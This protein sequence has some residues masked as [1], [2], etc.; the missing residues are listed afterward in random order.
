MISGGGGL[1]LVEATPD[2]NEQYVRRGTTLRGREPTQLTRLTENERVHAVPH[3]LPTGRAVLFAVQTSSLGW[4]IHIYSFDTEERWML[5]TGHSPSFA[6]SGHLL[7][8]R[9]TTLWA[10][11]FD[12]NRLEM[13]GE[14]VSVVENVATRTSGYS[15]YDLATV[16]TLVYQPARP[17]VGRRLVWV[18]RDGRE[19]PLAVEPSLYNAPRISPDGRK[20]AVQVGDS[21]SAQ[22]VVYDLATSTLIPLAFEPG[23]N[24]TP[25]WSPDGR[26]VAFSSNRDGQRNIYSKAA[27]GAGQTRRLTTSTGGQSPQAWSADGK[28]LVIMGQHSETGIDLHALSIDELTAEP[29]IQNPG[30]DFYPTISPDGRW[31]AYSSGVGG[32]NQVWIASFPNVSDNQWLITPE[33]GHSPVWARDRRELFYKTA[34]RQ[35]MMVIPIDTEPPFIAGAAARVFDAS[36]YR[37][38]STDRGRPWDLHPDGDRILMIRETPPDDEVPDGPDF[39]VVQNWFEELKERVPVP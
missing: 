32:R 20:V 3:F 11:P 30:P 31:L 17:Q 14:P 1:Q 23:F 27:D 37:R 34:D 5:L 12:P 2:E 19:V 15:H 36:P 33:G 21:D 22:V 13:M 26:L 25:V 28:T 29:L 16:G 24:G 8:A 10:V 18:Y 6:S 9:G 4:Q 7:F 38:M 35:W 39:V